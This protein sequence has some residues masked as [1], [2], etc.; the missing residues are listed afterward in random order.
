VLATGRSRPFVKTANAPDDDTRQCSSRWAGFYLSEPEHFRVLDQMA[1]VIP[2]PIRYLA[3]DSLRGLAALW[4]LLFHIWNRYYPGLGINLHPVALPSD[5]TVSMQITFALFG[6]GYVGVSLF[7][8]LSGFCIHL[9]QARAF[10]ATGFDQLVALNFFRRRFWRLYPAYFASLALTALMLGLFPVA[11]WLLRG[12][13]FS[14]VEAFG[15]R[16]AL[17]N[18][19]FLQQAFPDSLGFNG[20]YWTLLYEVQFYAFYPVLLWS[21][22]RFGFGAVAV[23]LLGCELAFIFHPLPIRNVF[24][25]R[26]FEWYL[27]MLIAERTAS[28][29]QTTSGW[30]AV[31]GFLSGVAVTFSVAAWPYRDL[32]FSIGC[33]GLMPSVLA[34]RT[35]LFASAPLVWLGM[36]S[37]SLYLV[38]VPII[39]VVWNTGSLAVTFVNLNENVARSL[40]LIAVPLALIVAAVSYRWFEKPFLR[41]YPTSTVPK[42][43]AALGTSGQITG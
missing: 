41:G 3:V 30:I 21:A 26:Y 15:L 38:H 19:L 28:G 43:P 22:R 39:D 10:A 7:F 5:A 20:V 11:L 17:A 2:R 31:A 40:S 6:Y 33:A 9:P 4:V 8:V 29:R 25:D 34:G 36:I 32:L 42:V 12:K 24:L 35:R 16:D 27:G 14:L 1:P 23:A 18:A 37:Y 13:P